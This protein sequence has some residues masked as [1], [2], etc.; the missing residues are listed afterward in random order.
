MFPQIKVK[1]SNMHPDGTQATTPRPGQ[2]K[3]IRFHTIV[4]PVLGSVDSC[5]TV[6]VGLQYVELGC[7]GNT[8]VAKDVFFQTPGNTIVV[9]DGC[10]GVGFH[11]TIT[12]QN[13]GPSDSSERFLLVRFTQE[14]LRQDRGQ[15]ELPITLDS[16]DVNAA[17]DSSGK[18]EGSWDAAELDK[19][20]TLETTSGGERDVR[21]SVFVMSEWSADGKKLYLSFHLSAIDR[22][23][24]WEAEANV[25]SMEF[26]EGAQ[27][28]V[29]L[30]CAS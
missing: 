18:K 22:E 15:F 8:K 13:N 23:K 28:G 9:P 19:F 1:N 6:I 27:L 26:Q 14:S 29:T 25:E 30:T 10:S 20:V 5:L 12:M 24:R 3:M 16:F 4:G 11:G 7:D 2:D 21:P 17:T